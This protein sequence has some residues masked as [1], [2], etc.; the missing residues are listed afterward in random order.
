MAIENIITPSLLQIKNEYIVPEL[1]RIED[2]EETIKKPTPHERFH[3]A[4]VQ[5]QGVGTFFDFY[6]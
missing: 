3:K 4:D 2:E 5:D 1:K 6:A